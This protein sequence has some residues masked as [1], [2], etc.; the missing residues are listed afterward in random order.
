MIS[1]GECQL[2]IQAHQSIME[3]RNEV[4][5]PDSSDNGQGN[6]DIL[7]DVL[8]PK[9]IW[10]STLSRRHGLCNTFSRIMLSIHSQTSSKDLKEFCIYHPIYCVFLAEESCGLVFRFGV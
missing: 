10:I 5:C 3:V 2:S 6:E 1:A 9:S 7:E 4:E 8:K